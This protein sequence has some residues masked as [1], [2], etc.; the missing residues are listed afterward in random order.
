MRELR[1]YR[2]ILSGQDS[3]RFMI[4][5]E[6]SIGLIKMIIQRLLHRILSCL[7][8]NTL[9]P[10]TRDLKQMHAQREQVDEL[11]FKTEI[12][13]FCSIL[14]GRD[15]LSEGISLGLASSSQHSELIEAF[16]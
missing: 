10:I 9:M 8:L 3:R 2:S 1:N 15:S 11:S 7:C 5:H 6:L 4:P 16:S 13:M 12:R 14:A